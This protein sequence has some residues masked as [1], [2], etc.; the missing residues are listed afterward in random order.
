MLAAAR[1]RATATTPRTL[2]AMG[3]DEPNLRETKKKK[4]PFPDSNLK[5][6]RTRV[7]ARQS[8]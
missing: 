6:T 1:N 4:L 7:Y 8:L 3:L 2:Y 5:R